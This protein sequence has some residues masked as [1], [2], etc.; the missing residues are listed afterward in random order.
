MLS[1]LARLIA[2]PLCVGCK[3]EGI[4]LCRDCVRKIEPQLP[5]CTY[6][7]KHNE[8]L[9]CRGCIFKSGVD[10]IIVVGLYN[11][12]LRATTG[13]IK[14]N[15]QKYL[16]KPAAKVLAE[17]ICLGDR[18]LDAII[19]VPSSPT[20]IRQRGFDHTKEL[21]KE[22][23]KIT[24]INVK[25]ALYRRKNQR[26]VG[27]NREIRLSQAKNQYDSIGKVDGNIL[28]VDDVITTG[29]TIAASATLLKKS[30]AKKV[31][32]AALAQD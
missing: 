18:S 32:V 31:F 7:K 26:Q 16:V 20:R 14:F 10:E 4:E 13:G 5:R 17:R 23:S 27:Q 28:L 11:G 3:R 24:G 6:C 25:Q 29:A 8:K 30:G 15:H 1:M 12:I 2:P 21:A 22:L 19:P 9:V